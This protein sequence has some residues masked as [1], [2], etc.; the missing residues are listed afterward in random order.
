MKVACHVTLAPPRHS[1]TVIPG[2][3][4]RR[5]RRQP[6]ATRKTSPPPPGRTRSPNQNR[7]SPEI[8]RN[9]RCHRLQD[10]R[11]ADQRAGDHDGHR[12]Q[13]IENAPTQNFAELMRTSPA[14]TSPRFP[15]ATSTSRARGATGTLATGT[16]GAARRPESVSGFL[17]LRDVGLP[18]GQPQRD[19]ADGSDP[20]TG[21]GGV[22]RQRALRRGQRHHQVTA[23]DAGH[24]VHRWALADSIASTDDSAQSAGTVFYISGTHA[25]AI[26][27]RWAYKL[28]AGGYTQDPLPR[29][30]GIIPCDIPAVAAVPATRIR[31][32]TTR[33]RRSP[34]STLASTTTIPAARSCRS[35]AALPA[36][37][38]SW[39]R[40]SG[41]LT[42]TTARSWAT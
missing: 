13:T 3:S 25:Q 17:R 10:R 40:V 20:W 2:C 27:D 39:N 5:P 4:P 18:A 7:T 23:G 35:R 42:S 6:P 1:L 8:R 9:R 24:H 26:N 29:P 37:R 38:G 11:E 19:E 30:T 16:A 14:S 15:R 22:G 34:S 33:G 21:L 32:S 28:S 31:R 36:P 41:R 12:F